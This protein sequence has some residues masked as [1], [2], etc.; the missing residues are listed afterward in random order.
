MKGNETSS[1]KKITIGLLWHSLTSDNLGVGALTESQMA[2]CLSAGEQAGVDIDFLIFGTRGGSDYAPAGVS[3]RKGGAVSIKQI[4]L[5]NSTFLGDLNQCDL[6]LDIGEGDSFTDIYGLRRFVVF[7]LSKIVVLAKRKPL[8]LSPQTIGPFDSWYTRRLASAIM[9]R[10]KRVYARDGQS[11][12]YLKSLGISEN[13]DEAIDVAFRLPYL[14]HEPKHTEQVQ[15]GINISGLLYAGG[16]TRNNQFGL[17][18]DYPKLIRELLNTWTKDQN[19]QVWLIPHVIPDNRPVEDDR[20]AIEAFTKEFPNVICAPH[21]K[22]PGEAKSFISR[23]DFMT[24]ARMHACIAAFSSGVPVVPLAYSRKFN[25]LFTSV[26]YP[27]VADGKTM[28]NKE[29]F[30]LIMKGF[31]ERELLAAQINNGMKIAENN[32]QRYEQY[33]SNCM[34]EK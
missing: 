11:L 12:A 16:Y 31:D 6:I 13:A 4:L 8:I 10:C 27:W 34:S 26:N 22:S 5:G 17:T 19:N 30:E 14:R 28:N 20:E 32:L 9:K 21:F 33:I 2:I 29:A 18:L 23:M 25:G 1:R 15:I 24:G 3:F 7:F